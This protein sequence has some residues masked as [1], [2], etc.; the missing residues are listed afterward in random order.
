MHAV[1]EDALA[2]KGFQRRSIHDVDSAAQD[3][4]DTDLDSGVLKYT[5]RP[6]PIEFYQDI[7]VTIR[8]GCSPRDRPENRRVTDPAALQVTFMRLQHGQN[9]MKSA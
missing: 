5:H 2:Q 8:P 9:L 4:R 6:L 7:N 3:F 1:A